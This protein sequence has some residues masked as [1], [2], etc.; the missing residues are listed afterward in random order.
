MTESDAVKLYDYSVVPHKM[1]EGLFM[2]H[3]DT[4][5]T[6]FRGYRDYSN[7][8]KTHYYTTDGITFTAEKDAIDVKEVSDD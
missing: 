2:Q 4:G 6:R 8:Y 3:L 7:L 5:Q 1:C